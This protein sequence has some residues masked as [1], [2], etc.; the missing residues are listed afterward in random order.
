MVL[1]FDERIFEM[2][3]QHKSRGKAPAHA[4]PQQEPS[5]TAVQL[6]EM[7]L[8]DCGCSSN[9][10]GLL[11]RVSR[12]IDTHVQRCLDELQYCL[13]SKPTPKPSASQENALDTA[14]RL[15]DAGWKAC[16]KFCDRDDVMYDGIVGNIGCPEFETAFDAASLQHA[17]RS[18]DE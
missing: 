18:S 10:T 11:D 2:T 5:C 6:A 4:S 14:R 13:E 16:A 9:N 12:R 1:L 7:V 8:S 15:F 17:R 3:E